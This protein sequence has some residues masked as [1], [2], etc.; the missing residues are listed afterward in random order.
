MYAS[1][2]ISQAKPRSILA[3]KLWSSQK[4]ST[5]EWHQ[6][7]FTNMATAMRW[8]H[9]GQFQLYLKYILTNGHTI[10]IVVN[11]GYL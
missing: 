7:S 2:D 1:E 6:L 11:R 5:F 4:Y 8:D 9:V 10:T 3:L